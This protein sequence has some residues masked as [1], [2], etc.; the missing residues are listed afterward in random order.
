MNQQQGFLAHADGT[1]AG[2]KSQQVAIEYRKTICPKDQVEILDLDVARLQREIDRLVI[3]RTDVESK[4]SKEE[5]AQYEASRVKPKT[6]L[7]KRAEIEEMNRRMNENKD[8]PG[9]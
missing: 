3:I 7:E 2:L 5:I 9:I 6:E 1:I 8:R 4:L